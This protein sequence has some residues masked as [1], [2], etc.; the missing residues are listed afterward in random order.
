MIIPQPG[1]KRPLSD[2]LNAALAWL[3]TGDTE[4]AELIC[5]VPG[6]TIRDWMREDSWEHLVN[7]A[8]R[9]KQS[10]LDAKFTKIIHRAV[11]E[12][13]DRLDNGDEVIAKDGTKVLR[14][15]SGREAAWIAAILSDKRAILRGEPTSISKRQNSREHLSEVQKQLEMVGKEVNPDPILETNKTLN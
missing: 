6:R 8:K 7:E 4:K 2:R 15:L 3:I 14:K 11:D 5:G 10:E 13:A 9:L 12:V 1:I